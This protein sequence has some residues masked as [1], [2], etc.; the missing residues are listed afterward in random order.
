MYCCDV[1]LCLNAEFDIFYWRDI[2]V[3]GKHES[4]YISGQTDIKPIQVALWQYWDVN[5]F[6]FLENIKFFQTKNKKDQESQNL[7]RYYFHSAFLQKSQKQSTNFQVWL[8]GTGDKSEKSNVPYDTENHK[9][10]IGSDLS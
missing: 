1:A 4:R 5:V 9:A 7:W 2:K 6:H 3:K 8:A 10:E